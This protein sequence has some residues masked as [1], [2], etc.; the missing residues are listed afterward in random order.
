MCIDILQVLLA[1]GPDG[2]VAAFPEMVIDLC[3][4]AG[5]DYAAIAF[6]GLEVCQGGLWWLA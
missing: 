2:G 6:V 4:T 3:D 1:V 5:A